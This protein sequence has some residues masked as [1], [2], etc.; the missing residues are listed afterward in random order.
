MEVLLLKDV[1]GLGRR[2]EI[3]HVAPGYARNSLFP[4]KA[5]IPMDAYAR[6]VKEKAE[7]IEKKTIEE[8]HERVERL[9][10]VTVEVLVSAGPKG[11]VFGSVKADE[12]EKALH[13]KG[14]HDFEIKLEKS[15]RELGEAK[16]V[17]D[18]GHGIRGEVN[19]IVRPR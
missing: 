17:V 7:A 12:I 19:V 3:K 16:A 6:A 10:E 18:F 5:A 11:N 4:E 14:F 13:E 2:M 15:I 1:K 9:T 8:A